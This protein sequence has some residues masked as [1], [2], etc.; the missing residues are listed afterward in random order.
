MISAQH[1]F[2]DGFLW[3][4]ATSSHQVEGGS[5][6]ND[7]TRWEAEAGHILH[8]HTSGDACG[9]WAG[10]WAEDFDLAADHGHSTI[11]LSLEWARIEPG[12][13]QFDGEALA[14]YRE[15]INGARERG[16]VPMVTLHHF[17]NPTWFVDQGGWLQSESMELFRSYAREA[18]EALG[19]LVNLWVTINEP[20]VYAYAA[21]ASGEF[22]P[23]LVHYPSVLLVTENL[24]KAHAAAYRSI[25]RI[26]PMAQVGVAHHIRMME[27]A[28]PW[29]G[30]DRWLA[31]LRSGLFN[32]SIPAALAD[33]RLRQLWRRSRIPEAAGTQDFFGLNYYTREFARF[34]PL[35]PRDILDLGHFHPDDEV[36]PSGFIASS[37]D[38]FWGALRY[39]RSFGLPI[40][41][42]E[43]GVEGHDDGLRRRYILSHL[44]KLWLAANFSWRV[45]GYYHWT[46]VDNFE[47]DR[48]WTQPFG[49]WELDRETGDR[50][51]R[52]SADLFAE[53]CRTN[54]I[55]AELVQRYAPGLVD[56]LFPEDP[57]GDLRLL[58]TSSV[59]PQ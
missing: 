13:G 31:R 46:L 25:H 5:P 10:R 19:D 48:G 30:P 17:T 58:R 57:P 26:S 52:P 24:V 49:L 55:S 50:V 23:G 1:R 37:P 8:G 3:G 45:R 18:V 9:W 22:P 39:A 14:Y 40:Y 42:T 41:V 21:Y 59:S 33:G 7:W 27:P 51:K 36:S 54:T 28:R 32:H 53:I 34:N 44:R 35:H 43:N 15:I 12:P 16:L 2:P 47:W 20:N 56:S 4:T 11:R 29:Y 38:G 6:P